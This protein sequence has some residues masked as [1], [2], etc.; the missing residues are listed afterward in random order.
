MI[1]GQKPKKQN[2]KTNFF[3]D[4]LNKKAYQIFIENLVPCESNLNVI[5]YML[6]SVLMSTYFTNCRKKLAHG[7][8][9]VLRRAR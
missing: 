1:K 9:N 6:V 5:I 7:Q 4:L 3:L 2:M 8:K